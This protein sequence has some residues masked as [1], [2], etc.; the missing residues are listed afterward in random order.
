MSERLE[1]QSNPTCCKE[2]NPYQHWIRVL[3]GA[4]AT[5]LITSAAPLLSNSQNPSSMQ[6]PSV[7]LDSSWVLVVLVI[8]VL[9]LLLFGISLVRFVTVNQKA[10]MAQFSHQPRVLIL[11]IPALLVVLAAGWFAP[12]DVLWFRYCELMAGILWLVRAA[13]AFHIGASRESVVPFAGALR[14]NLFVLVLIIV[15]FAL[16]LPLRVVLPAVSDA[17][18]WQIVLTVGPLIISG[19]AVWRL[20]PWGQL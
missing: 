5:A 3:S 7:P 19:A 1:Q 10:F 8:Q 6:S 18:Y 17:L 16:F 20:T 14:S 4:G 12:R 9:T 2:D 15:L 11:E 13:A